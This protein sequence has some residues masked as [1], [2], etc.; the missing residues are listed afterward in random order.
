MKLRVLKDFVDLAEPLLI[1]GNIYEFVDD[2][3]DNLLNLSI[4]GIYNTPTMLRID[5]EEN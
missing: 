1:N 3:P 4:S 2:I 5:L